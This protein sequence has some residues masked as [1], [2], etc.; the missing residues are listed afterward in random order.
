MPSVPVPAPPV[1]TTTGPVLPHVDGDTLGAAGIVG[2]GAA[3]LSAIGSVGSFLA[4]PF[5]APG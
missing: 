4:H 3:V 1:V 2:F 5:G